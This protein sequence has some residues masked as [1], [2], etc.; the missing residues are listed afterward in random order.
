MR[1]DL[2][3]AVRGVN[4]RTFF[5]RSTT[6]ET[7]A[8]AGAHLAVITSVF[9]PQIKHSYLELFCELC[10]ASIAKAASAAA[11]TEEEAAKDP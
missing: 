3:P 2:V 11:P 4:L 9:F 10:T 8:S 6:T 7:T 1:R 5:R